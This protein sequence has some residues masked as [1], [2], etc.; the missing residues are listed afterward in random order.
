M[1]CTPPPCGALVAIDLKTGAQPGTPARRSRRLSAPGPRDFPAPL[2]SPNLGGPIVTAGGVVFIGA[3]IDHFLRAFDVET[4]RELWSGPLPE[5]ARRRP[6]AIRSGRNRTSRSRWAE[7]ELRGGR[8]RGGV[9]PGPSRKSWR[10][11]RDLTKGPVGGH[12]LQLAGFIA[13]ST[14]F[15]TLYF[16]ADLY[17]VGRLGKEAIAGVGMA[18][19]LMFLVLA[20]TQSLGVGRHLRSSR[21]R[22]AGRTAC[23]PS[24]SSTRPSSLSVLAGLA[25]GL[26]A[27]PLRGGLRALA[28]RRS[29]HRRGRASPYLDW[30]LPALFLAVPDGRDGRRP[31]RHGRHE[32]ADRHPGGHGAAE[33]RAR[34][35]RSSSAGRSGRPLGVAGAALASFVA[36]GVGVVAFALYFH[37]ATSPLRFRPADWAPRVRGCGARS[38]RRPARGRR[39]S[40]SCPY[41]WCSSTTSSGRSARP[42]RRASASDVRV[43]QALFLPVIAIAFAT[44]PVAGQ[45][46]GARLGDRVREAF[47]SAARP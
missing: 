17:F 4:G 39:S 2:G 35:R 44:A 9:P 32:G 41:T 40:R 29:R 1:P 11:L 16:L 30:F 23:A 18:G 3:T 43:V 27:F 8:L 19:N 22:W 33:H 15:Q 34:A 31:A 25:F 14:A 12:I 24:C 47:Y 45:N 13:L 36:I 20:L 46:F 42:R 37:R 10:S 6:W 26:A 7:A 21:R 28:R 38:S 5:A